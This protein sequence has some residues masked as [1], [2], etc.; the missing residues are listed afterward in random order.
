[1]QYILINRL[2]DAHIVVRY[3]YTPGCSLSNH[4]L[5]DLA[6]RAYCYECNIIALLHKA[7]LAH[8]D[9]LKRTT[10]LLERT[11]TTRITYHERTHTWLCCGIHHTAQFTLVVR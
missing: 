10:P 3:T 6:Q 8:L 11:G 1:M 4:V 7:T 5:H 2:E 9:C